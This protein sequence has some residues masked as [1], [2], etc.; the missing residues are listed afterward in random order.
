M[1]KW[2]GGKSNDIGG[3]CHLGELRIKINT[4]RGLGD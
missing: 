4:K 2:S 3:G 1:C